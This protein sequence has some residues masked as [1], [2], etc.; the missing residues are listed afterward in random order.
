ME[1]TPRDG[2]LARGANLRGVGDQVGGH[3]HGGH[4]PS[5]A[6]AHASVTRLGVLVHEAAAGGAH[7]DGGN[8]ARRAAG[9]HLT[10]GVVAKAEAREVAHVPQV[11]ADLHGHPDAVAG[12]QRGGTGIQIGELR[13]VL[14]HDA[15]GL[16]AAAGQAHAALG[17]D[18]DAL[19]VL[20]DPAAD[21]RAGLVG[22]ELHAGAAQPHGEVLALAL[23]DVLTQLV[24]VARVVLAAAKGKV[25]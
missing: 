25:Q 5:S 2:L 7:L 23:V 9:A 8:A 11:G 14:D 1:A 21:D 18:G 13:V 16:K 24:V 22:D 10:L 19:A 6:E 3:G 20:L 4:V 12:V 17:L 15:V